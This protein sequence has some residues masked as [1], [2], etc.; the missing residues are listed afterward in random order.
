MR[1]ARIAFF[2]A[3]AIATAAAQSGLTLVRTTPLQGNTRHVQGIDFDERRLWVTSVDRTDHK[4]YLQEFAL[5]TGEHVRTVNVESGN[6]F[7]PGGLSVDG[8]SLWLPVAEYRRDSTSLIQKRSVR[9]FEVESQF[10]VADHIGCLAAGPGILIGANWD[11][12]MFYIWD[13]T[14]RL[15]RKVPNPTPNAY[16]DLKFVEGAL[17]GGGLLP[18]KA[19]AVD[20]LEYPSLKLLRRLT[21]GETTK[22]VPYT[23][24]GMALRGDRLLLLP[25]D[26]P[27]RLFEFRVE[28][29]K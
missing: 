15:I 3:F 29:A 19:G 18:G 16:Q 21:T 10:E 1:S 23:N 11:S 28:P 4:G 13:R 2:A 27:S 25:E 6:R 5:A 12:R 22:A 17:V 8:A 7:H 24:E 14:G 26:A 9:T 20:W